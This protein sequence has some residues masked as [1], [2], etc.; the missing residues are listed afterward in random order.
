LFQA[1]PDTTACYGHACLPSDFDAVFEWEN[2][3]VGSDEH[4]Y[5]AG[6]PGHHPRAFGA[7][8]R[9]L[10]RAVAR[11]ERQVECALRKMTSRVAETF[12][13]D[14][15]GRLRDGGRADFCLWDLSKIADNATPENPAL[16]ADGVALLFLDGSPAYAPAPPRVPDASAEK[17]T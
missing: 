8:A 9:A 17:K 15:V 3:L 5:S 7:F 13:L 4:I 12:R 6:D 2:G 11:G 16:P 1:Y 14:G 10:R